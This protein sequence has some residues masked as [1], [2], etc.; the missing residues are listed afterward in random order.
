MDHLTNRD[1]RWS[2]SGNE[3]FTG[4]VWNSRI[5]EGEGGM[6]MIVVTHELH[7]AQEAADR[8][9]FLQEGLIV[10]EG[11]PEKVLN[12]PDDER[13]RQFLRRFLTIPTAGGGSD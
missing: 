1:R 3:H 11:P 8:V 9:V 10:E 4:S 5:T 13:T 7:F 12:D 6:T 2:H